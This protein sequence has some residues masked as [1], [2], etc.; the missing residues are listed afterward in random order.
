MKRLCTKPLLWL[1]IACVLALLTLSG[2]STEA[3]A[4]PIADQSRD[5]LDDDG[6][7]VINA[8]DKCPATPHSAIVDNDGCPTFVERTESN[9]LH[10]LFA[11]DS[12][13]IPDEFLSQIKRMADFLA[14]YA[15]ARIELKGYASPVGASEYNLGLSKRRAKVVRQQLIDYGVSP[16]RIKTLG[17]GDSEPVT[18][19]TI[20]QSNALSRRVTARVRGEKGNVLEEWTIFSLRAD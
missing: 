8:R 20:E 3:E 4:P 7:G 10:I 13:V 2:C 18:A 14:T 11:N 15:D 6:D 5:L 12:T 16:N 17:F 19:S 9:D 1:T